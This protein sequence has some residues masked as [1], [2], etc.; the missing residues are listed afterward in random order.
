MEDDW[1]KL[2][3]HREDAADHVNP[4]LRREARSHEAVC[5]DLPAGKREVIVEGMLLVG[6]VAPLEVGLD[7]WPKLKELPL[8]ELVAS[9]QLL[10]APGLLLA[11]EAVDPEARLLEAVLHVPLLDKAPV[12]VF[13]VVC[14]KRQIRH[15]VQPSCVDFCEVVAQILLPACR[16]RLG[17]DVLNAERLITKVVDDV[18]PFEAVSVFKTIEEIVL[19]TRDPAEVPLFERL[20]E[21]GV[22]WEMSAALL[23][24]KN[25][26]QHV[27]IRTAVLD[28]SQD[29]AV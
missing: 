24:E 16:K 15:A 19:V 14:G 9:L 23:G 17:H 3:N 26:V 21:L 7:G 11:D 12:A 27:R 4:G 8:H 5:G 13:G 28:A 20:H 10:L 25:L 1:I 18:D 2:V 6:V 29:L 22:I